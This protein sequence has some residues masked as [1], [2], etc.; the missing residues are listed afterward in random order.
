MQARCK[1]PV[2]NHPASPKRSLQPPLPMTFPRTVL[3][4]GKIDAFDKDRVAEA[5][6][7]KS[8]TTLPSGASAHGNAGLFA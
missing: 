4:H 3:H 2:V 5:A 6:P 1:G 7:A 8:V